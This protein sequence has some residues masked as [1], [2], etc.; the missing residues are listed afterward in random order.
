MSKKEGEKYKEMLD[1]LVGTRGAYIL[2][3][4]LN[5]L[6]KVPTS[7]LSTTLRNLGSG[8]HAIVFDGTLDMDVLKIAE[9]VKVKYIVAMDSK[10]NPKMSK[11]DIITKANFA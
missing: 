10:V 6:G 3:K 9:R 7:E 2:D 5:I 1:E 11:L 8:I 4:E